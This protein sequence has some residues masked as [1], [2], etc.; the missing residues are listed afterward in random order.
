M[1]EMIGAS[2][3]LAR[4]GL[5]GG[6]SGDPR[7]DFGTASSSAS[8]AAA[9]QVKYDPFPRGRSAPQ[10][11]GWGGS[12][13][14]RGVFNGEKENEEARKAEA[15][16]LFASEGFDAK[17]YTMLVESLS[18]VGGGDGLDG[19]WGR[20][21]KNARNGPSDARAD[22]GNTTGG[23]GGDASM[24]AGLVSLNSYLSHHHTMIIASC[25]GDAQRWALTGAEDRR[26]RGRKEEWE[27]SE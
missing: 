26:R 2:R 14:A 9:K 3:E 27:V 18:G 17:G 1:K 6:L 15:D 13:G 19:G 22:N 16:L 23:G 12:L 20:S 7:G 25:V 8:S 24:D 21:T 5:R 11:G 4:G 10:G